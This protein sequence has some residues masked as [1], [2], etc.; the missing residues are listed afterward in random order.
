VK[1]ELRSSLVITSEFHKRLI[2]AGQNADPK[3]LNC[4]YRLHELQ[5]RIHGKQSL[6]ETPVLKQGAEKLLVLQLPAGLDT[7]GNPVF[8]QVEARE[9]EKADHYEL[10]KSPLFIRNLAS[11]DIFHFSKLNPGL[12]TVKE[13]SGMLEVRVFRKSAIDAL[14]EQLSPEVEKLDGRL[15]IQTDHALSYSIHVNNGFAPIEALFDGAMADYP[16][17]VWYYGNIYDPVDGI[18]PLYW[19]N[20]FLNQI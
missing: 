10:L 19:W 5:T 8:E 17:S 1:I 18:T 3:R 14:A 2:D 16:D 9:L 20:S 13:R 7:S 4:Y 12:L 11:G 15:E 6:N